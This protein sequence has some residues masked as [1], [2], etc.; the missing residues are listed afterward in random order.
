MLLNGDS[1]MCNDH[2]KFDPGKYD[3][4]DPY[5]EFSHAPQTQVLPISCCSECETRKQNLSNLSPPD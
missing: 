4:C 3:P 1:I 5:D 2:Q